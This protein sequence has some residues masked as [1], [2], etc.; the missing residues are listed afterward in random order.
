MT[1][2]VGPNDDTPLEC[3]PGAPTEKWRL[4]DE[5]VAPPAKC[6]ACACAA[7]KGECSQP[8]EKIEI[9]AGACGES[10]VASSPFDGPPNWTG[11]CSS[12]GGLS[13]G[14]MCGNELCAQSV[15]ASPLP[16]PKDDACLPTTAVPLSTKEFAWQMRAIACEAETPTGACKSTTQ[17]CAAE[18]G[19]E[20]R[21]CVYEKGVYSLSDCPDEYNAS[22]HHL[23]PHEPIDDRGCTACACGVPVGSACIGMMRL[24][25][26]A[27]CST[28]LVNLLLG[29][30]SE[31]CTGVIPA[32]SA[33]G[34][35]WRLIH[36]LRCWHV[37][38]NRRRQRA[39]RAATPPVRSR[40]AA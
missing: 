3:P 12:E 25:N 11:T 4:Y 22:V 36:V 20:W 19:P 18:P 37:A 24:Y 31:N 26:D 10:S 15:W 39:P 7:S 13:A 40:S 23:Y 1:L 34:A 6:E 28:E 17:Y 5:L 21:T 8:S 2:Y 9:R 33:I 32:G 27:A 16:P 30:M 14:T 38:Y 29:S 35:K